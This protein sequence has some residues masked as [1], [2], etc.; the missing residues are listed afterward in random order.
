MKHVEGDKNYYAYAHLPDTDRH[1]K[2]T[3]FSPPLRTAPVFGGIAGIMSQEASDA[4]DGLDQMPSLS[5]KSRETG[6]MQDM[7]RRVLAASWV[8][9]PGV[10]NLLR[11]REATH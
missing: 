4:I 5:S 3:I 7:Y 1:Q 10:S 9:Q 8:A 2:L 6:E 11:R